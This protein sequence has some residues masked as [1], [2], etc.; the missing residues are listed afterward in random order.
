[1]RQ[2]RALPERGTM[3]GYNLPDGCYE[4]DLPGYYAKDVTVEVTC[5]GCGHSWEEEW[6]VETPGDYDADES[7]EKCG[8]SAKGEVG[9]EEWDWE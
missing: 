6:S 9:E 4:R 3:G 1:M 7:C 5:V 2:G 8:G